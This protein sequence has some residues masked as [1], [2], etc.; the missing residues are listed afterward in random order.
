MYSVGLDVDSR[1]YFTAATMVIALPTGIKVFSWQATMYGGKIHYY[2]PMLF[3]IAFIL[4]FTFGG[5]TGVIQANA[6]IDL[7]FHDTYYVVGHFHYVLSM[8]AVY[9]LIA[10]IYYWIGKI[11]GN[12]YSEVWGHV[13]FWIFTIAIN[14]VFFPMHFLGLA[15]LPRRIPD[16]PD[17]YIYWN[18]FM[19]L[20]SF[21]T[22]FS[23]IIF[24][25][26]FA[27]IVFRPNRHS[28]VA[29]RMRWISQ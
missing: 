22:F 20:G 24:L 23:L 11:T 4:L 8:G 16:Y 5:F 21:L 17:G 15:G 10:G 28:T 19:T 3:G 12:Q 27:F 18:Q 7:A 9:A 25:G 29:I 13:H 14:I 1:A 2:T 6:V 26:I